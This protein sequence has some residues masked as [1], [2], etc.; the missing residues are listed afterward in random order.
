MGRGGETLI[1]ANAERGSGAAELL[2]GCAESRTEALVSYH[3]RWGG[4]FGDT[5]ALELTMP[6]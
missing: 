2:A 6:L 5:A 1:T 3:P 4:L